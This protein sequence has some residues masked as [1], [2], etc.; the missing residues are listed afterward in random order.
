MRH[1]PNRSTYFLCLLR[2]LPK[3]SNA[4]KMKRHVSPVVRDKRS[5]HL[6]PKFKS[7]H[8]RPEIWVVAITFLAAF[9]RFYRLNDFPPALYLDEAWDAYDALRV[10]RT[11][12]LYL[13][14]GGSYGREPLMIHLQAFAF[15][16]FG[17]N[18]WALRLVPAI[19][20]TLT[21]PAVY[22]A[23]AE[24][25][26]GTT[27]GKWIGALAATILTVSFWH[28]DVSRL[29]PRVIFVPLF[30]VPAVWAFW[31]G[32]RTHSS[33]YY[34]WAGILSGL[35]LY[36][37]PAARF[38]PVL[39]VGFAALDTSRRWVWK[40][41]PP[42]DLRRATAQVA[43]M[44]IVMGVV[45]APLLIFYWQNPGAVFVRP[46]DTLITWSSPGEAAASL[47]ENVMRVVRLFVDR[48]DMNWRHNLPGRPA[49]DILGTA[50][51]WI[52]LCVA[53][54]RLSS[55]PAY[56]LLITWLIL[57][58]APTAAT[59]D[60]PHFLRAILALPAA[61]MLSA[62]GLTLAWERL[63]PRSRLAP[64]LV[65]VVALGSVLTFN[66][67]FSIWGPHRETYYEFDGSINAIVTRVMSQSTTAD[68][69]LP[70][71]VYGTPQ[72]QWALAKR[73]P[74]G[75]PYGKDVAASG[76]WVI[77]G[78]VQRVNVILGPRG[79]YVPEPFDDGQVAALKA[80]LK[81]GQ[82]V[83]TRFGDTVATT[84][85]LDDATAFVRPLDPE[86]RL[87]ANFGDQVRLFGYSFDNSTI[88]P[89]EKLRVTL[90]WQAL[91]EPNSDY[92]VSANLLDPAGE[93][94]AQRV[95]EPVFGAA[96]TSLWRQGEVVPDNFDIT[97]PADAH[98]GKYRLEVS[99]LDRKKADLLLP[100]VGPQ[101]RLSLDPIAVA[102]SPVTA[103]AI[104]HP[105]TVTI[106][107][108]A[109]ATLKGY[110]LAPA[111][112]GE[113][114]VL[115]LF[116]QPEHAMPVDYS[117]FVHLLDTNGN[118]I[119]QQDGPPQNGYAPTS[120]WR[121]GELIEDTHTLTLPDDM[122]RK[123]QIALGVYDSATGQRLAILDQ[124]GRR[125]PNDAWH[126]PVEVA[127]Q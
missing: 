124:D 50:G 61:C 27:R 107:D 81:G 28:V 100:L 62:N 38:I 29:S 52:G 66:D 118:L 97:V 4:Q 65:A 85:W 3:A 73:F 23:A 122:T 125:Q 54:V 34:V 121:P 114:L 51:F 91:H 64:L 32:W 123:F 11:G 48:G 87:D 103:Q 6:A 45:S 20:G 117:V 31:R 19:I 75:V 40:Q 98:E 55:T 1:R 35:S 112:A 12:S 16:L 92:F 104:T 79:V 2:N 21:V 10:L 43:L 33:R 7:W 99:L 77:T 56:L 25:F 93:S 17:S 24:L 57:N 60:A 14:F 95:S 53:L 78:P 101:D 9:L 22:R 96:S 115:T 58:L 88:A 102:R 5:A 37:Y 120:W 90:Y 108:P 109:L 70:M 63:V 113:D 71:S 84:L 82:A 74:Q 110:N 8:F 15:L 59:V 83:T 72:M 119:A 111:I 105:L 26:E 116:W 41:A 13:Y 30:G 69:I 86:R 67:Y 18:A 89:G 126:L 36:T 46:G 42:I 94:Y 68:V 106:G 47:G 127:S 49:F 44:T 39:L 80:L 76:A